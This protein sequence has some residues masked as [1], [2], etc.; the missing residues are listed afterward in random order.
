MRKI[1]AMAIGLILISSISQAQTKTSKINGQVIDGS[2]KTIEAATISLLKAKDSSIVKFSVADKTGHFQFENIPAGEYL[3][4]VSAVGHTKGYS[5]KISISEDQANVSL[6]T[7][8]L[9]PTAKGIAGVTVTSTRPFI[10]QKSRQ[11]HYQC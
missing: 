7:I 11:N 8:E 10:E 3:V 5:E 9:V 2:Q 4:S 6:K 1:L